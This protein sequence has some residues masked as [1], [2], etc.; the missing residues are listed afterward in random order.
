MFSDADTVQ[1]IFDAARELFI[2]SEQRFEHGHYYTL[3]TV[4]EVVPVE[5]DQ[6]RLIP[7][8]FVLYQNYPNPFNPSTVIRWQLAV[9]SMVELSVYNML[10]EKVATLISKRMNPGNH[11][12][13]FDGKDLAS[14]IY[15]YQLTAGNFREIKKMVLLH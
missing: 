5:P 9:G 7:G 2:V 1:G 13:I 10:G 6:Q 11:T 8:E 14:G 3:G 4:E 12:C 15:Y